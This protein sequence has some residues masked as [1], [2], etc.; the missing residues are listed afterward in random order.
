M[1]KKSAV[2]KQPHATG[3]RQFFYLFEEFVDSVDNP[4][5]EMVWLLI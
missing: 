1:L 4:G 2:K 3:W 5:T